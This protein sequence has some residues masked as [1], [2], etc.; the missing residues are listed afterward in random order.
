MI[1]DYVLNDEQTSGVRGVHHGLQIGKRA[2]MRIHRE[3]IA[4]GIAVILAIAILH[5]G[6][7]P[8]GCRAES[9]DVIQLLLDALEVAAVDTGATVRVERAGGIVIRRI[10]VLKTVG[11]NLVDVLLLPETIVSGLSRTPG[12]KKNHRR[13]A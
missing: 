2:P 9:F 3:K 4:A 7:N 13:Q 11:E 5:D 12:M 8:D 6:G 1:D 10:A